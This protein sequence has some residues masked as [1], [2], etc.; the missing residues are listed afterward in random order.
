[1]VKYY[2]GRRKGIRS[3]LH[4][5]R[6]NLPRTYR[7]GVMRKT[8]KKVFARSGYTATVPLFRAVEL[9]TRTRCN[10]KCSFCAASLLFDKRE[11]ILMPAELYD[12]IL[13]E[14]AGYQYTGTLRFF[15]NNEPLLDKRL[16]EF[17][18]MAHARLP[19]V[20]T[21]VHT[22][23]LKLNPRNGRELLDAG[24][25]QLL[26][27]NYTEKGTMHRGV[28]AFLKEVAPDFP[29]REIEFY[30]RLLDEKLAN[31]GGTSPNGHLEPDPLPLH[32]MLPF[33]E[34]VVTADGSVTICC[35][36]HYFDSA[37]GNLY[38]NSLKEIWEGETFTQLRQNL[39]KADRSQHKLCEVCDFRGYKEQHMTNRESFSNRLIGEYL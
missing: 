38:S 39:A 4:H 28:E 9:E 21:E 19:G 12:Q 35:Q 23:G 16:P 27:N 34:I 15:V 22:N 29:D 1:M 11:D 3:W 10:S 37:A 13:N 30:L 6:Q 26:I 36:D 33:E 7:I 2:W 20:R 32:C 31:R 8:G 18:R 25:T 24:L 17:I 5:I 14:L